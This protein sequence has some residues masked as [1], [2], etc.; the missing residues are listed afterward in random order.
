MDSG[1]PPACPDGEGAGFVELVPEFACVDNDHDTP[2]H[3]D[4]EKFLGIGLGASEPRCVV[5]VNLS[6]G[7][8]AE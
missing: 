8:S 4:T 2:R 1:V 3:R 7:E 5:I 6:D